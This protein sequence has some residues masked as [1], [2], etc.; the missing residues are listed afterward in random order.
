MGDS[1]ISNLLR[2]AFEPKNIYDPRI[3]KVVINLLIEYSRLIPILD[4]DPS[5]HVKDISK[6]LKNNLKTL[7]K[8]IKITESSIIAEGLNNPQKIDILIKTNLYEIEEA[9]KKFGLGE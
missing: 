5:E 9:F 4:T 3:I 1:E 6:D 8:I 2:D 7:Q